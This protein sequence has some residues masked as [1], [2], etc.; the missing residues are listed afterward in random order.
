MSLFFEP[1]FSNSSRVTFTDNIQHFKTCLISRSY[2]KKL[3]EQI[4]PEVNYADRKNSSNTET[5]NAQEVSTL[6]DAISTIVTMFE[7]HT[8]GQMACN[9][10]T[11][12]TLRGP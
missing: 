7:K 9:T 5:D 8:N 12:I 11:T 1:F 4:L 6:R 10:R 2:P 3:V